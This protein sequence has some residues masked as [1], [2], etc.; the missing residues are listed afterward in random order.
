MPSADVRPGQGSGSAAG[1]DTTRLLHL[2]LDAVVTGGRAVSAVAA[3]H[4]L[5]WW[6]FIDMV[7]A[8]ALVL[9]NPD[10]VS[11]QMPVRRLGRPGSP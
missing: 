8:A 11:M 9:A 4:A 3:E 1:P 6:T 5:G 2:V 7:N 10:T